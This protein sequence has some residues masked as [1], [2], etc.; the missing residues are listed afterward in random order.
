M[1]L[2]A[3]L[4]DHDV[5][6][7]RR[8]QAYGIQMALPAVFRLAA[9]RFLPGFFELQFQHRKLTLSC[10]RWAAAAALL[11][12]T[13]LAAFS[14]SFFT[15]CFDVIQPL[16]LGSDHELYAKTGT[17]PGGF[18]LNRI[19]KKDR[20]PVLLRIRRDFGVNKI[21]AMRLA[22]NTDDIFPEGPDSLLSF[23]WKTYECR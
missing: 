20:L 13:D 11:K 10:Y 19:F 16:F 8:W 9:Y 22:G 15:P 5:N 23:I 14:R 4:C 21:L 12:N 3:R 18:L 17:E 2:L 6:Q 1:D 7:V